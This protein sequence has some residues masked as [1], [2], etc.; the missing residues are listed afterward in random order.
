[1]NL[2]IDN[3]EELFGLLDL[4]IAVTDDKEL[5]ETRNILI[6]M[7]SQVI[8]MKDKTNARLDGGIGTRIHELGEYRVKKQNV[9][10]MRDIHYSGSP[11]S[12]DVGID[13]YLLFGGLI[14]GLMQDKHPDGL[15]NTNVYKDTIISFNYDLVLDRALDKQ[16]FPLAID[17]VVNREYFKKIDPNCDSPAYRLPRVKLLKMH[18]SIGF[19]VCSKCG[20]V[21]ADNS[22]A[23]KKC[24]LCDSDLSNVSSLILP[25][26]WNKAEHKNKILDIWKEG[27]HELS[28][29]RRIIIIGY[30][31][32]ETDIFFK[33]LLG[34]S[35]SQ[36]KRLE[37]F[38]VVDPNEA[39]GNKY[40]NMMNQ[41]FGERNFFYIKTGFPSVLH[42][43]DYVN[44]RNLI[45][46]RVQ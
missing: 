45:N 9:N 1:M 20:I 3:I 6:N 29:A 12:Y 31:F 39:V 4:N 24:V 8:E 2:D 11:N 22:K 27:Y 28:N 30:S 13:S 19:K 44:F 25:P 42:S 21:V 23:P 38:I 18:G 7:I 5:S 46:R 16:I 10:Y 41:K 36:N 15:Y 37:K 33:H 40:K 26:T 35:L 32:P 43:S 17:Y 34:V 14:T